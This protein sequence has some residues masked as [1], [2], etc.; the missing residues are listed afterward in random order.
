[1]K[2]L[3]IV[4]LLV[5]ISITCQA[6]INMATVNENTKLTAKL[7]KMAFEEIK[8]LAVKVD[9]LQKRVIELENNCLVLKVDSIIHGYEYRFWEADS[10]KMIG[11]P[12]YVRQYGIEPFKERKK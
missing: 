7:F 1:M 6:Q 4:V 3:L 5:I 9:S 2:T 12:V 10:T 8:V 11:K